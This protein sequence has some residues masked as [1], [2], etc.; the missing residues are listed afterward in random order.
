MTQD[1][2]TDLGILAIESKLSKT[3]N[4]DQKDRK[5]RSI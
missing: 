2:L 4:F 1:Q 5:A 3:F